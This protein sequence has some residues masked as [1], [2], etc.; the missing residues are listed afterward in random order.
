MSEDTYPVC[1]RCGDEV[2]PDDYDEGKE[3]CVYCME[4]MSR[5]FVSYGDYGEF[6]TCLATDAAHAREQCADANGEPI[7]GVWRGEQ[8]EGPMRNREGWV[9]SMT[10]DAATSAGSPHERRLRDQVCPQCQKPFRLVWNDYTRIGG[11]YTVQTLHVRS[12]PSGG[13]YDVSI[14]CPH[15]DYGEEL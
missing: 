2:L 6:F 1:P 10:G 11:E 13:V 4:E 12:C 7:H 3:S 15:C 5:Y 9:M 8:E 14:R